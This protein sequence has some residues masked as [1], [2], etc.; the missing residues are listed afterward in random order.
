MLYKQNSHLCCKY[1]TSLAHLYSVPSLGGG[2]AGVAGVHQEKR[3]ALF[4][5]SAESTFLL[6]EKKNSNVTS[7]ILFVSVGL[8]VS[9]EMFKKSQYT[10][11]RQSHA[12][13][14]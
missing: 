5:G 13:S 1:R 8:H 7:I 14:K 12:I 9:A 6:V 10:V 3:Q 2:G 4:L 11:T